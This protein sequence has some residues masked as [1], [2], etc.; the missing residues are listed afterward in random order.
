MFNRTRTRI[1]VSRIIAYLV[2][3]VVMWFAPHGWESPILLATT[4]YYPIIILYSI[5]CMDKIRYKEWRPRIEAE[6][7]TKIAQV[8]DATCRYSDRQLDP[9]RD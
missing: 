5:R 3:P 2:P 1:V 8:Y 4:I 7:Y 6:T 9:A